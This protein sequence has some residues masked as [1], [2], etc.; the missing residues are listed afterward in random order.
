M[1][2][3]A[4]HT[5][6]QNRLHEARPGTGRTVAIKLPASITYAAGTIL[7]ELIGNN[8]VQLLTRAG[9]ISGG[10]WT[11][12]FGG[13]TTSAMAYNAD[14]ATIQAAIEALSTVGAGNILVTGGPISTTNVTLT[15]VNKLGYTN[16]TAVT[17]DITS[18]T[19]GGSL[20][21][22]TTTAGSSGTPG[23]FKQYSSSATDGS[24]LPKGLLEWG[25]TTD[26]NGMIVEENGSLSR[27]G[28]MYEKGAFKKD[29][30]TS[31]TETI[32]ALMG[33]RFLHG[34]SASANSYGTFEF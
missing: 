18:I 32:I 28:S 22:S 21:P 29:D 27:T 25:V 15:F 3:S 7:G 2:T 20:T 8:E 30:V 1:A 13:Q 19:G 14:A 23:T 4:T 12:T 17:V 11:L 31:M 6:N 34:T 24:Q 5:F 33:G 9:T 16:V 10:T 26:A